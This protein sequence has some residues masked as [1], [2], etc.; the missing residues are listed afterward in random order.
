MG[1]E[2]SRFGGFS[3][4]LESSELITFKVGYHFNESSK[5]LH[6]KE[7]SQNIENQDTQKLQKLL[8]WNR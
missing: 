5:L 3:G 4:F 7:T 2:K 8:F 1:T 6:E